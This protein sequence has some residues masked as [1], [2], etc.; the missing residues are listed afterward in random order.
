MERKFEI[1]LKLALKGLSNKKSEY[2]C[3]VGREIQC[4]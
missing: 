4:L 1:H 3:A 2:S